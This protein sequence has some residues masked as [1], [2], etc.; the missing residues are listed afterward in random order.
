M[1]SKRFYNSL[2]FYAAVVSQIIFPI[3]FVLFGMVLAVT[4]PG[5]DQDDPKRTLSLNNSA[6]FGGNLSIFYVQFGSVDFDNTPFILSVSRPRKLSCY[7][8]HVLCML[9]LWQYI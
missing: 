1:F 3:I 7:I 8:Y 6:L 2:R 9:N 5:R 4:G